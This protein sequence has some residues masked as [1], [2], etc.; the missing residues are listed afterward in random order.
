MSGVTSQLSSEETLVRC[1]ILKAQPGESLAILMLRAWFNDQTQCCEYFLSSLDPATREEW[2]SSS[3]QL[4]S[5]KSH[6]RSCSSGFDQKAKQRMG[7]HKCLSMLRFGNFAWWA[8]CV[9]RAGQEIGSLDRFI[10][11]LGTVECAHECF[12]PWF[13]PGGNVKSPRLLN[14]A[15][16]ARK[17][18]DHGFLRREQRPLLARGAL[19]GAAISVDDVKPRNT[20]HAEE[21]YREEDARRA[22]EERA[23]EY[24]KERFGKSTRMDL[25]E[26]WF[27]E[28]AHKTSS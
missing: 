3:Q 14:A 20:D 17:L 8:K 5:L 25:A 18:A 7:E 9:F 24:I 21:I 19:R 26:N 10:E 22:L 11:N 2:T 13:V 16:A 28:V 4:E 27:C 23:A 1:R 6:Y 15:D 12:K